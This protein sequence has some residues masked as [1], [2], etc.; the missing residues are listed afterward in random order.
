MC[1]G[2]GHQLRNVRFPQEAGMPDTT[3]DAGRLVLLGGGTQQ[4][5]RNLDSRGEGQETLRRGRLPVERGSSY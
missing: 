2:G 4:S 3:V 5:L 1:G